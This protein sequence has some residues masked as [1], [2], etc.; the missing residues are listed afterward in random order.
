MMPR[1]LGQSKLDWSTPT[2]FLSLKPQIEKVFASS[3]PTKKDCQLSSHV[4]TTT[5]FSFWTL[6]VKSPA[7]AQVG[8]SQ[9]TITKAS[10]RSPLMSRLWGLMVTEAIRN[11]TTHHHTVSVMASQ[12]QN[13]PA[14]AAIAP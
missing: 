13:L 2:E 10:R 9:E 3:K 14:V 1:S 8:K 4:F 11:C 5:T 6:A 7:I 12:S